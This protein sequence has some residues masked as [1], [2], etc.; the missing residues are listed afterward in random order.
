MDSLVVKGTLVMHCCLKIGPYFA[1]QLAPGLLDCFLYSSSTIVC[2]FTI[3]F[4]DFA[5]FSPY[6][7]VPSQNGIILPLP[8]MPYLRDGLLQSPIFPNILPWLRVF[9][10]A[11]LVY[12]AA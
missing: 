7:L 10:A 4:L 5:I 6:Q 8:K 11:L 1:L 9:R 2:C 3:Q 12:T